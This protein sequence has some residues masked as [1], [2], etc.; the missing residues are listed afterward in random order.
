MLRTWVCLAYV[1]DGALL[2]EPRK[3]TR[4]LNGKRLVEDVRREGEEA[5]MV[6][7]VWSGPC[8]ADEDC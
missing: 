6:L 5:A 8:D 4:N 3:L 2:D 7:F 1:W